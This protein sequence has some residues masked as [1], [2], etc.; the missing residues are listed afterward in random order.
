MQALEQRFPTDGIPRP[1]HWSGFRVRPDSFEFWQ[2]MPF[3]LH[4][5][6]VFARQGEAWAVEKLFP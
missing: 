6:T 1:L 2:D 4:D 5:R 3:R